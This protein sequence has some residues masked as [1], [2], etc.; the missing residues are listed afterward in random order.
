MNKALYVSAALALALSG[1][2]FAGGAKHSKSSAGA[3]TSASAQI[4]AADCEQLSVASAKAACLRSANAGAKSS[5]AIGA[6]D[7]APAS[8]L[9]G[10]GADKSSPTATKGKKDD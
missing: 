3:D 5:T 10:G 6:S 8:G 9:A 7:S 1:T 4:S 2:A